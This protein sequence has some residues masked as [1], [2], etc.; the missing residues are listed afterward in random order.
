ME[1]INQTLKEKYNNFKIENP[2]TRIR[3]A[4]KSLETTE[5][6]LVALGD[7]NQALR[8]DFKDLF[9][10]LPAL[11]PIMALT[12]NDHA[13]HERK[14]T[15][16][17]AGFHGQVGL[18]VNP[19][20]DLR[21]FMTDW[22]F[23]FAVEEKERRSLQ[24]FDR[25]GSA[26]Q[27]IYLTEESN[28]Q[29]FDQLI[30]EFAFDN[31]NLRSIVRGVPEDLNEKSDSEIDT[32]NFQQE[33]RDLKDTH[34]FFGI[35]K[36][37]ELTRIQSMRLAP[38]GFTQKIATNQAESLLNL[39]SSS[40]IDFMVFVGNKNCLQIHTGKANRIVRTGP[41]INILDEKFNLHLRDTQID[42]LWIV[43]KP[44]ALG[45]VHSVEAFDK[46][47]NL[48]VQ[49]FGKRKPNIPEREDWRTLIK[50]LEN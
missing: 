8:P 11:G 27:K 18:V 46:A 47:G 31:N 12:R 48:I 29:V 39:V 24:F 26:I 15:Y 45:L 40:G 23:V 9:N 38:E 37:Y 10:A 33:W 21:L 3:D 4:A 35:V 25:Y 43:K 2:K 16:S 20:I 5:A 28:A 49:F 50:Q 44:T 1:T 14:G 19:D 30:E 13:V 36:K 17:K 34:D 22:A 6:E 32:A 7:N 42:S 41:W